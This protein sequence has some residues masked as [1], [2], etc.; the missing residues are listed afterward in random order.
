M[1]P[2]SSMSDQ[3]SISLSVNELQVIDAALAEMPYRLAAPVINK[4]NEQL[5]NEPNQAKR[6]YDKTT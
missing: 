2:S 4:I 5:K 6:C 3:I 1:E